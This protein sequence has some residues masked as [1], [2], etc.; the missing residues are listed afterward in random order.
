MTLEP[1]DDRDAAEKFNKYVDL[2]I[3]DDKINIHEKF[4]FL[5]KLQ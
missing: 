3:V 1:G 5:I 2:L 4:V